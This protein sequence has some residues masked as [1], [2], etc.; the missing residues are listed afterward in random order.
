MP[1]TKEEEKDKGAKGATGSGT[2][3]ADIRASA[4]PV[5]E[6]DR[7]AVSAAVLQ[8]S[9]SRNLSD[10]LYERRKLGALEVEQLMRE[11]R[12]A[13]DWPRVASVIGHLVSTFSDSA[14]GNARKGGLIALAATAIGLGDDIERFLDQLVPPVLRCFRDQDSKIRY[15]A[16]ESLYNLAK[17][18]RHR[19][20]QFYNQIFD[21]LC[22]LAADPDANVKNGAQLL[23][24]LMKD[25][26]T[27]HPAVL[28]ASLPEFIPLLAE[29]VYVLNPHCRSF[30]VAWVAA[31]DA[32]PEVHLLQYLPRFA[33]GLFAMLCDPS[34][35][36]R[37]E[38]HTC[39]SEFLR[40]ITD[41]LDKGLLQV[42][43]T[44]D[45][46]GRPAFDLAG[47]VRILISH[48]GTQEKSRGDDYTALTALQW[49]TTFLGTAVRFENS[50]SDA[51]EPKKEEKVLTPARV[52][53]PFAHELLGVI[54][55]SVAH[56]HR[57]IQE[58]AAG[59]PVVV[60]YCPKICSLFVLTCA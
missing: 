4:A 42:E 24:R 25:I 53:L 3:G 52:L 35:D 6:S 32:V 17:I 5:S 40:E 2:G 19:I 39:L 15:Y 48:A 59:A 27:E 26:V 1:R 12:H 56:K 34:R 28:A 58:A 11:L 41:Q 60:F 43:Q 14:Q 23:D 7:A 44:G 57:D 54:L 31:L 10:K 46:G 22:K 55:Q 20:L 38:A 50:N 8:L 21:A 33:D 47:M 51:A 36:I 45:G 49:I 30:L 37:T 13:Q 18:A 16:C 9:V 29:R